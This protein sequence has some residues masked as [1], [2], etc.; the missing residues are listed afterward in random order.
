MQMHS[1]RNAERLQCEKRFEPLCV[2][3]NDA[4]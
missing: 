2:P 4:L 1:V 3:R